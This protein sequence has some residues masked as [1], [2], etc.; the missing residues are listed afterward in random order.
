M[1]LEIY[2]DKPVYGTNDT[3]N[4]TAVIETQKEI[5]SVKAD[6]IPCAEIFPESFISLSSIQ[7]GSENTAVS[8]VYADGI[9]TASVE[10]LNTSE[11]TLCIPASIENAESSSNTTAIICEALYADGTSER[12]YA[13][14]TLEKSDFFTVPLFCAAL[15]SSVL[16]AMICVKIS[17]KIFE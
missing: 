5:S 13:Q 4:Y 11:L 9:Y 1:K 8:S 2:A 15:F 3:I 10:G 14:L 12:G 6:I 17:K 16:I 7:A